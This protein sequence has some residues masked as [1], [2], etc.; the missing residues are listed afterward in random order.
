M[1]LEEI[2]LNWPQLISS[3]VGLGLGIALVHYTMSMFGPPLIAEFG[4][5]KAQ[6]AL[7]GSFPL[8]TIFFVPVAGRFTDR[9][10]PWF[11]AAIGFTAISLGFLGFSLMNGSLTQ[12]MA[13]YFAQYVFGVFTTSLVFGRVI[14][15]RFDAA[16]GLALSFVMMGPP[17]AAAILAPLLDEAIQN[18]G[19]RSAF[20]LL[21]ILSLAG[22]IL[23]LLLMGP[24][25]RTAIA[26]QAATA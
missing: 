2:R 15:E 9:F 13:I 19:W 26:V 14:V 7:I 23:A 20:Q 21:A 5:T 17:L 16:R 24:R 18:Y 12:F 6:F 1:Y 22:G 8:L 4:W 11:A 25:S 3:F 10:G